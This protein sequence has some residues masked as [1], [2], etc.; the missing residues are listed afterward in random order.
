LAAVVV[1]SDS[2]QKI[3]REHGKLEVSRQLKQFLQLNV[4][5]VAIPRRWRYVESLPVN[6]QGK[7]THAQLRAL[8]QEPAKMIA[9]TYTE[10]VRDLDHAEFDVQWRRDLPYFKGHF[11]DA[12]VLPGVAQV[13]WAIQ[14]GREAFAISANFQS[15]HGLKFHHVVFPD[16]VTRLKLQYDVARRCLSFSY[17]TATKQHSSGKIFFHA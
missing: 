11:P 6:A 17:A 8:F 1:L 3:L 4:E 14:I 13:H 9:P 2:G 10:R 16:E 7:T 5:Q 15:M 12:P